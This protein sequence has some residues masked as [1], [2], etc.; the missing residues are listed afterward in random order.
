MPDYDKPHFYLVK[1]LLDINSKIKDV[2][3]SDGNFNFDNTK[4]KEFRH[5]NKKLEK[6][7]NEEI[8]RNEVLYGIPTHAD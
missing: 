8:K 7:L 4:L 3:R 6:I 1:I 5:K 2:F